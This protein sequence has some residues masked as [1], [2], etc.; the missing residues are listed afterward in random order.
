MAT[1]KFNIDEVL[2]GAK[3]VQRSGEPAKFVSYTPEAEEETV[4]W[5]D[6]AG[7]LQLSYATGGYYS[8]GR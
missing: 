4:V 7:T 8:F 5:L 2:A 1:R 3:I 6:N